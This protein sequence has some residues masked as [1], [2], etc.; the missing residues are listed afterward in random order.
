M[1]HHPIATSWYS[2]NGPVLFILLLIA[3]VIFSPVFTNEY[4]YLD[5]AYQLWKRNTDSNY[6]MFARHGRLLSGIYFQKAFHYITTVHGLIYLRVISLAGWIFSSW[7]LFYCSKEWV[8]QLNLSPYLPFL[9][10]VFCICSSSVTIYIAWASCSQLFL[11]FIFGL[12]SGHILFL[13]LINPRKSRFN[14][15]LAAIMGIFSLLIYQVSFGVFILPF[16]MLWLSKEPIQK[17]RALTTAIVV[18]FMTYLLYFLLFLSY[19]KVLHTAHDSRTELAFQPLKKISFFFGSPLS[20]AWSLNM[21]QN[22]HNIYSQLFPV[23]LMLIWLILL[24][25]QTL[26]RQAKAILVQLGV[27]ILLLIFSYM[28][29]LIAKESFSSYRTMIALAL[30]VFTL[31]S[32]AILQAIKTEKGRLLISGGLVVLLSFIGY[33]NYNRKFAGPLQK[34]YAALDQLPVFRT[35]KPQDTIIFIRAD[36]KLFQ[37]LYGVKSYKDEFGAPSTLRDWT[38]ENLT[39]Q[40][41]KEKNGTEAAN[42]VTI[43]QFADM[44]GYN[45][46]MKIK[47]LKPVLIDMNELLKK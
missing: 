47:P 42:D 19:R 27:I 30:C 8:K 37:Q 17:K 36:A 29:S 33:L 24:I 31:F 18:Y 10:A 3:G 15:V 1:D 20:Q 45:D 43:Y 14:F 44:S 5:E 40:I 35:M 41:I 16:L 25:R 12:I 46:S 9:L 38:P 4:L 32:L 23:V 11:S 34:E 13:S 7:L 2:R 26:P 22:L 6:E 39:R 28:P 21:L